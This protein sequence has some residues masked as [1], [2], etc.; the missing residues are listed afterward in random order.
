M[1]DI[2]RLAI[3]L[4]LA[5]LMVLANTIV[6]TIMLGAVGAE[7]LAGATL[8]IQLFLLLV[9]FGDGVVLA[10]A[11]AYTQ[12]LGGDDRRGRAAAMRGTVLVCLGLSLA[13]V[14]IMYAAEHLFALAG[15]DSGLSSLSGEYNRIAA[16]SVLPTLLSIAGWELAS[17]HDKASC[18]L[19]ASVLGFFTNIGL[20]WVFIYGNLDVAPMGVKGASLAT[21]VSSVVVLATIGIYLRRELREL[22][23]CHVGLPAS[24]RAALDIL[25]LGAPIGV[26]EIATV[27]FFASSTYLVSVYGA[28][29]LAAHA[30]A[31]QVTELA[32]VFVLGFG[33]AATIKVGLL[34]GARRDAELKQVIGDLILGCI[35][36]SLLI[37]LL[38]VL[39]AGD[40]PRLFLGFA[41]V[42]LEHSQALATQLI[43]IG[44]TFTVLDALQIVYLGILRGLQDTAVP[45]VHVLVGYW[46]I[47]V[48]CGLLLS[49]PLGFG[50]QGVWF[51]LSVGLLAVC[52]GLFWRLRHRVAEISGAPVASQGN[53]PLNMER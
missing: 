3:P 38:M 8:G 36:I 35:F 51:G 10:F 28:E 27:G 39:L 40:L 50:S 21:L 17:A 22:L 16:L 9:V 32:I 11:P 37:C 48:P 30:V 45:M 46:L 34:Y 13:A 53:E 18:V 52:A 19:V 25:K 5:N 1:R 42:P 41:A 14:C 6:D 15:I 43:L 20:N 4:G 47:G 23:A 26:I 12:A 24:C 44:A 33:E 49:G 31:Y 29:V 7:A 2:Y